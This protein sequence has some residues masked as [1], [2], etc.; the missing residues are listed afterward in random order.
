MVNGGQS[1]KDNQQ[2]SAIEKFPISAPTSSLSKGGGAQRETLCVGERR[3]SSRGSLLAGQRAA[4]LPD[5][6]LIPAGTDHSLAAEFLCYPFFIE[7][8]SRA[9]ASTA[10]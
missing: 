6:D 9:N 7:H 2:G 1:H 5:P 10:A 4:I 3:G 8:Y